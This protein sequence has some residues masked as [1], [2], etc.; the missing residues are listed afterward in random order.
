MTQRGS[1][2]ETAIRTVS[3]IWSE[4]PVHSFSTN[5]I[6]RRVYDDVHPEP[7]LVE[8]ALGP[9]CLELGEGG[10]RGHRDGEQVEERTG[11]N[12][13]HHPCLGE[14]RRA[15]P[16]LGDRV[17]MPFGIE[18]FDVGVILIDRQDVADSW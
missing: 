2:R 6:L 5:P 3:P 11:R 13:R 9:K 1:D 16:R 10:G 15:Q 18:A 17:A 4:W 14:E 12:G 7:A 8:A